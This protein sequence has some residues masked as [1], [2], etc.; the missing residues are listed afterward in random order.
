M[1]ARRHF[2]LAVFFAVLL[3]AGSLVQGSGLF[4]FRMYAA[5]PD[6]RISVAAWN[7]GG[8]EWRVSPTALAARAGG[9]L[10]NTLSGTDRWKHVMAPRYLADHIDDLTRLACSAAPGAARVSVTVDRR[11]SADAPVITTT[12]TRTCP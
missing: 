1:T 11:A 9:E 8:A 7:Q 12:A 5:S 4:A 3:P 6:C 10:G 2:A